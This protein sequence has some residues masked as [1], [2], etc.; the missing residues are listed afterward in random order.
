MEAQQKQGQGVPLSIHVKDITGRRFYHLLVKQFSHSEKKRSFW[1]CICDCGNER[2]CKGKDL[3]NGEIASCGCT[4]I[5]RKIPNP[6]KRLLKNIK[7]KDSCWMWGNKN[8]HNMFLLNGKN[9]GAHRASWILHKGE[10]PNGLFVCHHCDNPGC[11]NPEHLFLGTAKDN[12]HDMINK[13]R[14]IQV[15]GEKNGSCKLKEE[16]VFKMRE[17][18]K[19]NFSYQYIAKIFGMSLSATFSAIKGRSWKHI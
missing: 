17:I 9:M 5:K 14:S 19:Q 6:L 13:G 2:I 8:L 18:K 4:R 7:E 10:I 1:K 3:L 15:R 11:V 16:D 12:V